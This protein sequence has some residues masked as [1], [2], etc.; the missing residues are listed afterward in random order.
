MLYS[1][2]EY[3]P[4]ESGK[5]DYFSTW[6]WETKYIFPH[7]HQYSEILYVL[8]GTMTLFLNGEQ[9][10]APAGCGVFILP[11][12]VHS[13][14]QTTQNTTRHIMHSEAFVPEFFKKMNDNT[15]P[16]KRVIDLTKAAPLLEQLDDITH[17]DGM[18]ITGV[19]NLL[20]AEFWEQCEP[21]VG[22]KKETDIG[23]R[24]IDYVQTHFL[25]DISLRSA[26]KELGY[27]EKYLSAVVSRMTDMHFRLFLNAYRVEY[28]CRLACM[29][30]NKNKTITELA[31]ES[32]F[33][34]MQTFNRVFRQI[35]GITPGQFRSSK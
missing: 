7:M 18:R 32:G 27:H 11:Y 20:Y 13:F 8:S 15:F 30:E 23:C 21:A 10:C 25:Q 3:Y 28:F 19:L 17:D 2:I 5:H 24:V 31:C 6:K 22:P 14:T 4:D 35:K 29:E 16:T 33:T 26:A 12:E 1:A 9:L 34:T